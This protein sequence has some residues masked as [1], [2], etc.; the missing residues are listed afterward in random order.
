MKAY[1]RLFAFA[2]LLAFLQ[3]TNAQQASGCGTEISPNGFEFYRSIVKQA[4]ANKGADFAESALPVNVPVHFHIIRRNDGTGFSGLTVAE[5]L[6]ECDAALDTVNQRYKAANIQFYRCLEPNIIMNDMFFDSINVGS[7]TQQAFT[8]ANFNPSVINVY[9]TRRVLSSAGSN[10]CGWAKFPT[11]AERW[12]IMNYGCL[13]D[14]NTFAHEMGHYFG[15]LHTHENFMGAENVTRD[16]TNACFDCDVDGDFLCDTPADPSLQLAN[17]N[18]LVNAS[19]MYT[20]TAMDACGVAYAPDTRNIMSYT[21]GTCGNRFSAG[22]LGII[23]QAY[24]NTRQAQLDNSICNQSPCYEDVMLPNN[25][26]TSSKKVNAQKTITSSEII[27][28]PPSEDVVYDA[29]Q[30]IFL[31]PGFHAKSG[32]RFH[33]YIDGCYIPPAA[34]NFIEVRNET[35]IFA[36]DHQA[37]SLLIAPNPTAGSTQ[38]RIRLSGN[39][40]STVSIHNLQGQMIQRWQL[41]ADPAEPTRTLR[42]EAD[43]VAPGLYFCTLETG[44]TSVTQKFMVTD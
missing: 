24:T 14:R 3:P 21:T 34:P 32:V 18:F 5:Q 29:G 25:T 41:I 10:R 16:P 37:A 26:I 2:W 11:D 7:A 38:I 19:C 12:V 28:T 20:G 30:T 17:G 31:A 4:K 13:D 27:K 43:E 33:A 44:S 15:L 23:S 36:V 1:L 8:A 9:F 39:D 40:V 6:A 35:S 22:Q 42:F